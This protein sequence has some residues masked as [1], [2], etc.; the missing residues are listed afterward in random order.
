MKHTLRV[1]WGILNVSKYLICQF[2]A[3][4]SSFEPYMETAVRYDYVV[5][6]GDRS[7]DIW[8]KTEFEF[9]SVTEMTQFVVIKGFTY[10]L[11]QIVRR[12]SY[13]TH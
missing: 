5:V 10:L 8:V 4:L 12:L 1:L 6:S 3:E 2:V 13:L 11:P 9:T 7:L